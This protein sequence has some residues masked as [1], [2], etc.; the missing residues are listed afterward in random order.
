MSEGFDSRGQALED[1]FFHQRDK[2]LLEQFRAS[3]ESAD[4]RK[5]ISQSTGITDPE[6]LDTL[7]NLDIKAETLAAFSLFP[8]IAVAWADGV[9]DDSERE[10][11]LNAADEKGIVKESQAF[12]LVESWLKQK[13]AHELEDAWKQ[14]VQSLKETMEPLAF[15]KLRD[16]V[17]NQAESVA[18][19]AGGLLGLVNR[20]SAIEKTKLKE[21]GSAFEG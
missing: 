6:M 19:S 16:E 4:A 3:L 14:F 1:M 21:L 15:A 17:M 11:V 12:E 10:A 8:L 13:P 9:L 20:I 18:E 2:E 7:V 5:A